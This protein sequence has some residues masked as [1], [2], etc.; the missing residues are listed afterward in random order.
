[1]NANALGE[2]PG[3]IR[4]KLRNQKIAFP[5]KLQ[6]MRKWLLVF[7]LLLMPLQFSWAAVSSYCQHE[8][9]P[10]SS[11][12]GH[13][14]HKH[15]DQSADQASNEAH[16]QLQSNKSLG[17]DV[18]C[19]NCHASCCAALPILSLDALAPEIFRLTPQDASLVSRS[20]FER[21]ERPQWLHLA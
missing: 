21:P 12:P 4:C 8:S 5:D 19:V 20:S 13:H 7:L 16:A 14:E 15:H 1:M 6:N 17:E 18:D 2:F 3:N 11:H 9:A 10:A